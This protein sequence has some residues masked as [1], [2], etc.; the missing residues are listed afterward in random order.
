MAETEDAKPITDADL[1]SSR[2]FYSMLSE[3]IGETPSKTTP[4]RGGV[5]TTSQSA[6]FIVNSSNDTVEELEPTTGQILNS[7]DLPEPAD[8]PEGLAFDGTYLYYV[9]GYGSNTIYQLDRYTGQVINSAFISGLG[10]IDALG[11]SGEE[12]YALVYS[13]S[14]IYKIDFATETVI[15][16][17]TSGSY[18]GGMTFGG[19]R[20]TIFVTDNSPSIMK[21]FEIDPSNWQVINSFNIPQSFAIGLSYSSSLGIL[22]LCDSYYHVMYALNPDDGSVYFSYV[23]SPGSA[24]AADETAGLPWITLSPLSGTITPGSYTDIEIA[25]NAAELY[26]CSYETDILILSNDPVNSTVTIPAYLLVTGASEPITII[27][28]D[29]MYALQAFGVNPDSAAI[30]LGDFIDGHTA[31]DIDPLSLLINDSIAPT[32]WSMFS[33]HPD[34]YCDG[35][36]IYAP[37]KDIIINYGVLFD[38]TEQ[39]YTLSGQFVDSIAFSA[40][41]TLIIIGHISGDL[42]ND[43]QINLSD[44]VYMINYLYMDGPSPVPMETG[45]VNCTGTIDIQ[46]VT[47]LIIYLYN[48]GPEPG[49]P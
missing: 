18:V 35:L 11:H 43:G 21:V 22:F 48:N 3:S 7:F 20:G 25:F 12:L 17:H 16:Q 2:Q 33:S 5:A 29:T 6:L 47:F 31:G 30:Y 34:F 40:Q 8:G 45:D 26:D 19:N 1:S 49:C 28:P 4:C 44:I 9:S 27:D 24:L 41:G 23:C 37:I 14:T 13:I 39:S 38:T 42:N 15:D 10:S 46:D 32:S 36:E